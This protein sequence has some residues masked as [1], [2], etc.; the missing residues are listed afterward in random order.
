MYM[1][2]DKLPK[3][4]VPQ[5]PDLLHEENNSVYIIGMHYLIYVDEMIHNVMA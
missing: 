1:T 2:L 5:F 3:P 4:S